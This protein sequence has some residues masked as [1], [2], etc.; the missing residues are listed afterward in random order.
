MYGKEEFTKIKG[1]ICTIPIASANIC[2]IL[3][4]PTD[5]NG[6]IVVELKRDLKVIWSQYSQMTYTRY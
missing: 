4:R 6:L 2:N 1:S 5:T 3:S